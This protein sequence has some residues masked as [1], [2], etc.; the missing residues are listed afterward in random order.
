M[1][2]ACCPGIEP[3][4]LCAIVLCT[5][6]LLCYVLLCSVLLRTYLKIEKYFLLVPQRGFIVFRLFNDFFHFVLFQ[7]PAFCGIVFFGMHGS[8]VSPEAINTNLFTNVALEDW[9]YRWPNHF[10]TR[11]PHRQTDEQTLSTE[12]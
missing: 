4:V 7:P 1:K 9:I 12:R 11:L 2:K 3:I 6:V 8:P 10:H 5:I